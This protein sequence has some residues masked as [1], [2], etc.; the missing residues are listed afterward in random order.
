[1]LGHPPA[2]GAFR[3]CLRFASNQRGRGCVVADTTS[4]R[5]QIMPLPHLSRPRHRASLSCAPGRR[6]LLPWAE[7]IAHTPWCTAATQLCN[8]LQTQPAARLVCRAAHA[9][10]APVCWA[11]WACVGQAHAGSP[12][13][14]RPCCAWHLLA[15]VIVMQAEG[16]AQ[17]AGGAHVW[18]RRNSW[19]R[20]DR[21]CRTR[22]RGLGRPVAY[23]RHGHRGVHV[24]HMAQAP[25]VEA[26]IFQ[27]PVRAATKPSCLHRVAGSEHVWHKAYAAPA[28]RCRMV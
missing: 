14:C 12:S 2:G 25:Q 4:G 18:S 8:V 6:Q 24:R 15:I 28:P 23:Q 11:C 9:P 10:P 5:S 20:R 19:R 13:Y 16:A 22:H 26:R 1:M 7:A 3:A 21:R 27:P 17:G